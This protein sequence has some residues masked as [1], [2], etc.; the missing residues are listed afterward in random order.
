[1]QAIPGVRLGS[2]ELF[3]NIET[4]VFLNF[5]GIGPPSTFVLDAV[6]EVIKDYSA[7][8]SYAIAKWIGRR[9][10]LRAQLA[11]LIN[12]PDPN[13]IA[14]VTSTT[15]GIIDLAFSMPWKAGEGIVLVRGEFPANVTTWLKA[16]EMHGL[17]VHWLEVEEILTPERAGF[18]KLEA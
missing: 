10:E 6:G 9:N 17:E 13:D 7:R 3:P 14:L 5:A 15:Q 18:A 8:G 16:A 4:K 11:T 12:A 1:M 2:R